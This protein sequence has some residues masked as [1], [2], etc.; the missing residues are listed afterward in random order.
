MV[1][2][3]CPTVYS[4]LV[5]RYYIK[6][7]LVAFDTKHAQTVAGIYCL[8]LARVNFFLIPINSHR[9]CQNLLSV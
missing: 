6:V 5:I 3:F 1:Q 4:V 9:K 8:E 2:F 7:G